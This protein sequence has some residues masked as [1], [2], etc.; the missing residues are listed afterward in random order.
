M[1][2]ALALWRTNPTNKQNNFFGLAIG[3]AVVAGGYAAGNIS[4]ATLNPA[5]AIGLEIAGA[6]RSAQ[7][8]G[9]AYAAA[10]LFGGII[11]AA[12]YR[13]ARQHELSESEQRP[14]FAS[15]VFCEFFGSFL[16]CATVG[17]SLTQHVNSTPWAAGAALSSIVYAVHD[18]SGGHINPAVTVAFFL[19][20]KCSLERGSKRWAHV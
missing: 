10:E 19:S 18:V 8:F 9:L 3:L 7:P 12:F 2:E 6:K 5:A 14:R 16:L 4:G 15:G 1:F 11:A 20:G 17:L 13:F